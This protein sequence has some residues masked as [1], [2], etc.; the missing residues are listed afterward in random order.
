MP[1]PQT[2]SDRTKWLLLALMTI[3]V[4]AVMLLVAEGAVRVRQALKYGSAETVEDLYTVDKDS[5]LRVPI[6]GKSSGPITINRL[7]FRGPDIA[8]KKEAGTIR[9]AFLGASTTFCAEVSSNEATWP[10][11]VADALAAQVPGRRLEYIN[12]GVPGYVVRRSIENLAVRVAPLEPDVIVIYH[13]ANDLSR[14]LRQ[15][16]AKE[17]VIERASLAE[18]S[19]LARQSL[20]WDLVE[21][22]VRILTSQAAA[23]QNAGRLKVAPSQLGDAFRQD[24][25]E[26]VSESKKRAKLVA[27]ATFAIQSRATQDEEQQRRG[28]ASAFVY[29]PFMTPK[30]LI[31]AYARYNDVIREVARD[32]GILLIEGES[33][34]PG[35]PVHFADTVHFTDAGSERMARRVTAVLAAAPGFRSIAGR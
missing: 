10:H 5:K 27:I 35:D 25:I 12:G 24:L 21:K 14:E 26:L 23:R 32:T 11:L 13:A 20:L 34:I 22:N 6:A 31:D 2:L 29:M 4:V 3:G 28:S 1:Q 16:A 15:L 19:W 9:I 17:G 8:A 7:G 33:S 18:R 30:S